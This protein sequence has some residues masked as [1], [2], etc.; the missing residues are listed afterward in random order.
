MNTPLGIVARVP[1]SRPTLPATPLILGLVC[2][3]LAALAAT[4]LARM[5]GLYLSLD[6]RPLA[7]PSRLPAAIA[8]DLT[9]VG[10]VATLVSAQGQGVYLLEGRIMQGRAALEVELQRIAKNPARRNLP[11][12]IRADS[13][14]TLGSLAE[15]T[16][17][18][19]QAGFPGILLATDP[20]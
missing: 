14:Q 3:A 9:R 1:V 6:G 10:S 8:P 7:L 15:L 5:P 16:E 13:S 12:L 11:V 20:P 18:V 2:T 17:S 19:R 4:Y